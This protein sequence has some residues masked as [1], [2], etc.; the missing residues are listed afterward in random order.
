MKTRI[1]LS[2]SQEAR[3]SKFREFSIGNLVDLWFIYAWSTSAFS[4]Q[5][6]T[7]YSTADMFVQ[8]LSLVFLRIYICQGE[9]KIRVFAWYNK[10]FTLRSCSCLLLPELL[11]AVLAEAMGFCCFMVLI[12]D[13]GPY[14]RWHLYTFCMFPG[15][16]FLPDSFSQSRSH[17]FLA[18]ILSEW[19]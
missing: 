16:A 19:I 15:F 18:F 7:L 4:F 1:S 17:L 3:A 5:F 8:R 2:L 14:T 10:F 12:P 11:T 13:L 6:L 9:K